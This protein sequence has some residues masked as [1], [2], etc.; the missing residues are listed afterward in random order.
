MGPFFPLYIIASLLLSLF[1]LMLSRGLIYRKRIIMFIVSV[2]SIYLAFNNIK[3]ILY[4]DKTGMANYVADVVLS[5]AEQLLI[6]L[7]LFVSLFIKRLY[8]K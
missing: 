7:I 5:T 2:S 4:A 3:S 8:K 1:L 6:G